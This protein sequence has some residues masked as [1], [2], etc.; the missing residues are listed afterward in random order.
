MITIDSQDDDDNRKKKAN[1]LEKENRL[2]RHCQ[3]Q[4]GGAAKLKDQD[5]LQTEPG[6]L[7]RLL[8]L[9]RKKE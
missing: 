4:N 7:A 8:K 2:L 6:L 1:R 5:K 9:F 3:A